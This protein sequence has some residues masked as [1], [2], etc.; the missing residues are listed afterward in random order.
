M[1]PGVN[2]ALPPGSPWAGSGWDRAAMSIKTLRRRELRRSTV[3]GIDGFGQVD[4]FVDES[5][6]DAHQADDDAD[7][8]D[9]QEQQIFDEN[10][11][12]SLLLLGF[13]EL[14][15]HVG[16][17]V[18]R[19]MDAMSGGWKSISR[20]GGRCN[21]KNQDNWDYRNFRSRHCVC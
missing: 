19:V 9:G 2:T 1:L 11:A 5:C 17:H 16:L 3:N 15:E 20:A 8:D 18:K 21:L 14:A 10:R 13:S 7:A 12:F 4:Q 6:P